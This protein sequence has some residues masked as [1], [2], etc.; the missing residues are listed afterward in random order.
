MDF[1]TFCR[2]LES[3]ADR[4]ADID[5]GKGTVVLAIRSELIEATIS[6]RAGGLTVT[7]NGQQWPAS[8]WICQ[9]IAQL[10]ILADR[11][12][13]LIEEEKYFVSPSG[14][15]LDD[16]NESPEELLRPIEDIPDALLTSLDQ[17]PAGVTNVIYL[18]S[19]AGE[20][21]TTLIN[22][23]A[24]LQA[25]LYKQKKVDWLLLP[26]SLGGR[27]F[28]RFDD[29]IVGTLMNRLRFNVLFYDSFVEL[30]RLGAIVPALDGFEE[31]FV[32]GS[33]GDA[34]SALGNLMQAMQS[35]G[36][37][38]IAAR[39]AYFQYKNLR[40]QTRLLDSMSGQSVSFSR[41]G[42]DRWDQQHF[43]A[44]AEK[45]EVEDANGIYDQVSNQLGAD[46]P[47]LTRAV[48]VERL[49]DVAEESEERLS[50]LARITDNPSDYFRQFVGSII[51]REAT[52]KWIDKSGEPAQPLLTVEEHYE[53]LS[54]IALEMWTT[55]SDRLPQDVMTFV[56]E[57]FSESRTKNR[58]ITQQIAERIKQHA[59]IVASDGG[60]YGFDHEEFYHFFL[61]EAVGKIAKTKDIGLLRRTMSQA[62]LPQMAQEAAARFISRNNMPRDEYTNVVNKTFLGESRISLTKENLCGLSIHVF[63]IVNGGGI[64]ISEGAF[65]ANALN[66]KR[67]AGVTFE[68]CYFQKT[69][70]VGSR[71]EEC[72]FDSCELD[73]LECDE[74]TELRDVVVRECQVVSF[75]PTG[76]ALSEYVPERILSSMRKRG[77]SVEQVEA[78]AK[79]FAAP[80]EQD[81]KVQVM[82][83]ALRAFMRATG[84]N[85]NTLKKRLGPQASL[86]LDEMLP[87]L[88]RH[89]V[90]EEV[91][92]RGSG[93]QKRY[94][95]GTS[96][97]RIAGAIESCEGNYERFVELAS[98]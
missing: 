57:M 98:G 88:K 14:A 89:G 72:V 70:L 8:Q 90:F 44:Y 75:S 6:Q 85:E 26:I 10:P 16:I 33:S 2:A 9:R 40:A 68:R 65:P 17:K 31:M 36:A 82:E 21:K 15:V 24:R 79:E 22:H 92:F 93:H 42:I 54:E 67:I 55:G 19:D 80:E 20:G 51:H 95:L 71:L 46:H 29:V 11:I 38:V 3:F 27:T 52:K 41:I 30:V 50:L 18:T 97:D 63:D 49:L 81:Q 94:K 96:F 83:R 34:I 5:I 45:R 91:P 87:E 43:L 4:P 25:E 53:L 48:L 58:V 37:T 59:L 12:L 61:G 74:S 77:F 13:E 39:K 84:V 60:R 56:A 47:L 78:E 66:G 76:D 23:A 62:V 86:F 35:S 69:S 73:G 28:M 7:E 1:P 64:T 32:E